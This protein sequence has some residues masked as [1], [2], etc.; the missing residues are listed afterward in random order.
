MAWG[1]I[2]SSSSGD[3]HLY[4]HPGP[5]VEVFHNDGRDVLILGAPSDFHAVPI[6]YIKSVGNNI[7]GDAV[8]LKCHDWTS[9]CKVAAGFYTGVLERGIV[10]MDSIRDLGHPSV[11]FCSNQCV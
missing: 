7:L 5:G 4:G 11:Q 2:V 8:P 9:A 3:S 10:G 6:L 1:F